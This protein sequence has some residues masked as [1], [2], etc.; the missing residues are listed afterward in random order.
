MAF[1][2]RAG[3]RRG[4]AFSS[5]A[6]PTPA[7]S[8]EGGA[9]D[10]DDRSAEAAT[11]E[12]AAK[13][14]AAEERQQSEAG[15]KRDEEVA[16]RQRALEG[17]KKKR[18]DER[19]EVK[20]K[21]EER[22]KN[23]AEAGAA[24][25]LSPDEQKAKSEA[26]MDRA[27]AAFEAEKARKAAA[28]E[29][30]RAAKSQTPGASGTTQGDE[31]DDS[32]VKA[33]AG[34]DRAK[35]AF[36]A[37]KA[38][39]AAA[40]ERVRAAKAQQASAKAEPAAKPAAKASADRALGSREF[41]SATE[42]ARLPTTS[43]AAAQKKP[44]AFEAAARSR[45]VHETSKESVESPPVIEGAAHAR[46][47]RETA[48]TRLPMQAGKS[49]EGAKGARRASYSPPSSD[50]D[51][52]PELPAK[53]G[54]R[55]SNS[56]SDEDKKPRHSSTRGAPR[57]YSP[58][59]SEDDDEPE[60]PEIDLEEGV[61][62]KIQKLKAKPEM[63]GLLG[64]LVEF[65][66]EKD[67]WQLRVEGHGDTLFNLKPENLRAISEQEYQEWEKERARKQSEMEELDFDKLVNSKISGEAMRSTGGAEG[68]IA[69]GPTSEGNAFDVSM[70]NSY[71]CA[72]EMTKALK[73]K[74][75]CVCEAN[76]SY[77]LLSAAYEEA[78]QLW[79]KGAFIHP[80]ENMG[81]QEIEQELWSRVLFQDEQRACWINAESGKALPLLV[82]NMT[83]L[84]N[85]L[86][87]EIARSLGIRWNSLWEGM[88]ACYSGDN[89][90]SFHLDNPHS[91]EEG[92]G[93]P[94]NG[95]RLSMAYY[96]NP[97]WDPS[98]GY[99]GGGL[100]V[101]LTDP[102]AAPSSAASART[103]DRL[104]IAPHADTLV[105]F[106]SDRMAHKVIETKGRDKWFVLW[107]WC[108]EGEPMGEFPIKVCE[109][110]G[111]PVDRGEGG[112]YQG[113][114]KADNIENTTNDS[115]GISEVD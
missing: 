17:A 109:R 10:E 78:K 52:K 64:E 102:G 107:M 60:F 55:K 98:T 45:G 19:A 37:E 14:R 80:M 75:V 44:S 2:Q 93:L 62:V 7:A 27:K 89:T 28:L 8:S 53:R 49:Q 86:A 99:N 111:I 25:A 46:A 50:E 33:Q 94:D 68:K 113:D 43:A 92:Q 41:E 32:R 20:R 97:H 65:E 21:L 24:P 74:G 57:S 48:Q 9:E 112:D 4:G 91:P 59:A 77:D 71:A 47:G 70:A 81:A 106:L 54:T 79:D 38:R 90:Y 96:I 3:G 6:G 30:A 51:E 82:Q 5:M 29:R 26:G 104:R 39:K 42:G 114:V 67:R 105:A 66:Y 87:P 12:A 18:E 35:A 115:G 61:L 36:E 11:N 40:L 110:H 16:Q 73:K 34:M 76:A 1:S 85:S 23:A 95:L 13:R 22:K 108:L 31:P 63:N 69:K 100:D 72:H 58:P 101:F 83:E 103:S 88:L 56:S 84:C 15:R